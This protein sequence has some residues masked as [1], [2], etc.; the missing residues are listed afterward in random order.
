MATKKATTSERL[1]HARADL[2]TIEQQ[3]N[4]IE[5]QRATALLGDDDARAVELDLQLVKLRAQARVLGDK[6]E[7]LTEQIEQEKRSAA[8]QQRAE[9]VDAFRQKLADG[10]AVARRMQ[11]TCAKLEKEFREVIRLREEARAAWPFGGDPHI[12]SVVNTVE[13]CAMSAGAVRT[14]LAYE[15]FRISHKPFLG[16]KP[17]A[18]GEVSLP[19]SACPDLRLEGLPEKIAASISASSDSTRFRFC[20]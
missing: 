3:I 19:G 10:D 6:A 11:S 4:D 2:Q 16:G 15:L 13:G 20:G 1:D 9:I 12:N 7:L 18:R 5:T 8:A 17:G 14:L